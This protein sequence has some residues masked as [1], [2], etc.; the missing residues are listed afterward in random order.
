[1]VRV[2]RRRKRPNVSRYGTINTEQL[3]V[4]WSPYIKAT[5]YTCIHSIIIT[6]SIDRCERK[7][8]YCSDYP[9]AN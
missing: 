8:M 5:W 2:E 3:T 4:R 9:D 1:M 7:P 6:P